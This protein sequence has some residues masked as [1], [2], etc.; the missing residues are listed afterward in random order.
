MN[1]KGKYKQA[2]RKKKIRKLKASQKIVWYQKQG[3]SDVFPAIK[4]LA[5][6]QLLS[7]ENDGGERERE[8]DRQDLVDI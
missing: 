3:T 5:R 7:F 8:R 6:F 1:W 4:F 2:N